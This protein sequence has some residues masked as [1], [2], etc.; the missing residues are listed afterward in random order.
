M[1]ERKCLNT[2]PCTCP[3]TK[4]VRHGRCCEC[5]AWHRKKGNPPNCYKFPPQEETQE[6]K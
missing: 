3:N 4:C 2:L 5:V 1:E 6:N